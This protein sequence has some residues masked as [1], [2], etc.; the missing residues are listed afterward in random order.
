MSGF[1]LSGKVAIVTGGGRGIG[2]A[3]T[4]RLAESGANVVIASR[5]MENLQATAQ[6]YASLPGKIHCVECHVGRADH[7]QNLV[8]ETEKVFGPADILVNNSATNIGQGPALDVTDEMLA[9]MFEI[10]VVS[11][12]RLIR[13]TVPK[14]IERKT[15]G[16][17]I[18]I[19]SIAGL[20]PQMGGLLYSATKASL[21]MMTRNWAMEFG[22]H[23]VRVNAIAPGLIE[24]DFSEY[25]WK[26]ENY[27]KKLETAQPIPRVGRPD[28]V[29]GMALYLASDESSFV[30]GQVFVV[31]G[32]AT[33]I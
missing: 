12:L 9:K 15:G 32:G 25:F 17:I 11:A 20:R 27:V 3:I 30:T 23:N 28:E 18:N 6:E 10:N 14:M 26:N 1:N 21:I 5:K 7:L 2:K 29:G 22:R 24:T 13:L 31:D 8:S 33:A 19:A 16:S 4:H